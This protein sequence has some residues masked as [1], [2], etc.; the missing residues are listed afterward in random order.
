M[1][2]HSCSVAAV[3]TTNRDAYIAHANRAWPHFRDRGALRMVE[4]WGED[5][6]PGK[7]TDFRRAVQAKDDEAVVFSWIEWPDRETADAAWQALTTDPAVAAEMGE[8]PFDGKRMIWGGFSPL[9]SEGDDRTAGWVWG[10][11][12]PVPAANRD[13]YE[14]SAAEGWAGMFRPNGALGSF[15]N[16]G[17]NVPHGEH[18]DMYRAVKAEDGEAV[19]FSWVAWPD[20]T[21]AE[22]AQRKMT[23]EMQAAGQMPEMPFD[24][25]RMIWGG[26]LPVVDLRAEAG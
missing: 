12:T 25:H 1:V 6:P 21:T 23:E 17:E 26:F 18:T 24:G 3:P 22:A 10:F 9:L 14:T 16:W 4:C 2:Y 15:E 20:R 8:M 11:L 13:A 19:A 5:I 7:T